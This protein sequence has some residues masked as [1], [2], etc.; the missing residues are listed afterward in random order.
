MKTIGKLIGLIL[1]SNST[2]CVN[3]AENIGVLHL[4]KKRSGQIKLMERQNTS[5]T[6]MYY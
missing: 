5:Y 3:G 6:P 2:N 1:A 4:K